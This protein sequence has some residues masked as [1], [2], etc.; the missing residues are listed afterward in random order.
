LNEEQDPSVVEKI[1]SKVSEILMAGEEIRYIAVQKKPLNYAPQ[2]V[3]LTN[4]RLIVYRLKLIGADFQD[5]I[6]RDLQ[7]VRLKEGVFGATLT[8]QI[9]GSPAPLVVD[10]LPKAQARRLYSIAQEMEEEARDQRRIRDLEER[11]A[12]SGAHLF[13]QP[14]SAPEPAA[15]AEDPV[16]V[17]Q[18]LKQMLDAGL[19]EQGEYDAKKTE[20][21]GR[22]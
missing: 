8:I 12:S 1:H 19:I 11:R 22:M 13:H 16:A 6:W 2:T 5:H 21:L 7:D 9:V 10:Y 18:K 17:L 20:I 3:A 14:T 15:T 4:K